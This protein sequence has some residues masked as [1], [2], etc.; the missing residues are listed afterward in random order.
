MV[1]VVDVVGAVDVAGIMSAS[2]VEGT[3]VVVVVVMVAAVVVT[4][5]GAVVLVLLLMVSVVATARN[6][7]PTLLRSPMPSLTSVGSGLLPSSACLCGPHRARWMAQAACML[8][9][10]QRLCPH[11]PHHRHYCYRHHHHRCSW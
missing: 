3:V 8:S 10:L 4:A 11:P 9:P 5:V 2:G 6:L 7:L 1:G